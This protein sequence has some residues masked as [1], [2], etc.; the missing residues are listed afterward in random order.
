MSERELDFSMSES[1][2]HSCKMACGVGG[3]LEE[4]NVCLHW[5]HRAVFVCTTGVGDEDV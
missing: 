1:E 5:H 3:C 4:V 2:F